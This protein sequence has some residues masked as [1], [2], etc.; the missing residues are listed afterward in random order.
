MTHQTLASL[1]DCGW[2][3]HLHTGFSRF[4]TFVP[5]TDRFI[6]TK[7]RAYIRKWRQLQLNLFWF[8][9]LRE[10]GWSFMTLVLGFYRISIESGFLFL[11][12]ICL[13]EGSTLLMIL[14]KM[15]LIHTV[16][17]ES[18][19]MLETLWIASK[20]CLSSFYYINI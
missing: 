8:S 4:L 9:Q 14:M 17:L 1:L 6:N 5:V 10:N 3:A 7:I 13:D 12:H 2:S 18:N 11:I 16:E 20:V 15:M 19:L